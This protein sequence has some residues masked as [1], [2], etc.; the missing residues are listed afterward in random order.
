MAED[1]GQVIHFE[2]T[3][4]DQKALQ[5][6]YSD[7][8]GWRLN[9]DFPGGYGMT[10]HGQTGIVVGVAGTQDGSAAWSPATP[11]GGHQR[12]AGQ[13]RVARW[14]HDHPALQPRRQRV[15]RPRGRPRRPHRGPLRVTH[16]GHPSASLSCYGSRGRTAA[17]REG[18]MATVEATTQKF[19]RILVD[20]F[21]DVRLRKDGFAL[22]V[23]STAAFV[24]SRPGRPT[25]TAIPGRSSTSGRRSGVTSRRPMSCSIGRPPTASSSAS[26]A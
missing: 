19:Q 13:G 10:D 4:K 11:R 21:N 6:Y 14:P 26:A 22:E 23:G 5:S 9:T 24:E 3:G 1:I 12:D 17:S 25:R 16:L 18:S 7:L 2:V 15:P 20:S 8:F